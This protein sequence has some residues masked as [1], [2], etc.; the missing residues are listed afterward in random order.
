[1]CHFALVLGVV[2]A[3]AGAAEPRFTEV[4]EQ[5]GVHFEHVNG[6]VGERWIVETVGA[7]V[8]V[9]DF[10]GDGRLDIWLVQG[11]PLA[12]RGG[13]LPRD[14]LFRNVGEGRELRFVDVT[15][16]SGV[17]STEYGMGIA[18]GDIDND[19]D[20]DVFIANFGPDRLYENLGD[21]RFRDIT[22]NAGLAANKWSVSAS[23]ADVD[24]DGL[25]DLYVVNYL[26]FTIEKNKVCRDIA[27]RAAYCAPSAYAAVADRLYRNVGEGRFQ[28][29]SVHA[30]ISAAAGPGLGV[31]S[32][33][34]DAD[35]D[36]DFYVANDGAANFL[37][38][39]DGTGRFIDGAELAFVAVNGNGAA[40]AGMGVDAEDFDADC[41]VDLFITHLATETNTL[42]VN[43]GGWFSDD[44]SKA[45]LAA[46]SGPFTGFGTGWFD[47]DNDG[48]MDIF[49]ANGAVSTIAALREAGDAYPLRQRNQLWLNDGSGRYGEVTDEP[50]LAVSEVSRGVAFGDLNNDGAVDIVAANNRGSARIYRNGAQASWLGLDLRGLQGQTAVGAEVWLD[51]N[52]C[53]RRRVATDGSFA[54]A[55][56]PR[57]VFGRGTD[58]APQ[59][60]R[61]RWPDGSAS[62]FG[63]LATGRYHRLQQ[64]ALAVVQGD[65]E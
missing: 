34:F 54:S 37:W 21:G 5:A 28:D 59:V 44:T 42:Y 47:A 33:D 60:V 48:D 15:A 22:R 18:T 65:N 26:D 13:E 7:G 20:A 3:V 32:H 11:G 61:V 45:G 56:D 46:S 2:S 39:N 64:P 9:F 53:M 23:F 43:Q 41:D 58:A 49:A 24:A 29:V 12:G 50:A 4:A 16:A 19:G 35:G 55:S 38:L 25:L 6:M 27:S 30:G 17:E 8:G 62:R 1:M 63:P 51:E 14:R 57:V 36:A 40:E 31:V 10:D 52:R